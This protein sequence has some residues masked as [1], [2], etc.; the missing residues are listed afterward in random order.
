MFE[1]RSDF[2]AHTSTQLYSIILNIAYIFF[3]P[4][5][6]HQRNFASTAANDHHFTQ[7]SCNGKFKCIH[8]KM[9]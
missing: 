9:T 5:C 3:E 7:V 6:L 4:S 1:I 2:V 8:K